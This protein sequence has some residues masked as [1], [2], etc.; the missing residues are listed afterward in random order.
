MKGITTV[1][2]GLGYMLC[3]RYHLKD[4][5]SIELS[6]KEIFQVPKS[7]EI[8]VKETKKYYTSKLALLVIRAIN[9]YNYNMNGVDITD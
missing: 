1:H 4:S 9:D 6:T 5:S 8:L 2:N 3:N 7:N